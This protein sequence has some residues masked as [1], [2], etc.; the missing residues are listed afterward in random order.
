MYHTG[1]LQA[2]RN[3]LLE[4]T[5]LVTWASVVLLSPIAAY[6]AAF[7]SR[8]VGPS[9]YAGDLVTLTTCTNIWLSALAGLWMWPIRGLGYARLMVPYAILFLGVNLGVSVAVT[10]KWGVIGPLAGTV[11][12]LL[13]V[14]A[15]SLPRLVNRVLGVRGLSLWAGALRPLCFG[16]PYATLVWFAARRWPPASWGQ[17]LAA[18]LVSGVV[19][20]A[21]FLITMPTAARRAWRERLASAWGSE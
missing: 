15:W 11:A 20:A 1:E 16:L 19:G 14:Y 4:L 21:L 5:T 9:L 10:I 12:A 8:W 7:V 13:S 3:R 17:L 18:F 6:N 2:C